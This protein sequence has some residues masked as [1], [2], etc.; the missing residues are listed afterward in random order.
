[1]TYI[2][3][4]RTIVYTEYSFNHAI[5]KDL[6]IVSKSIIFKPPFSYSF[7]T[8]KR[9][10]LSTP[11][12]RNLNNSWFNSLIASLGVGKSDAMKANL[13]IIRHFNGHLPI[14]GKTS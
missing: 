5:L 11:F 3:F 14:D 7:I 2:I 4:P 10:V 9:V 6:I 8:G 12:H 13:G 1:M